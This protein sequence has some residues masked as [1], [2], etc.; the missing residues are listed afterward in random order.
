MTSSD[1]SGN[2]IALGR[3]G[4][5]LANHDGS[6]V[7]GPTRVVILGEDALARAA[8]ADRLASQAH[9]SVIAQAASAAG[10]AAVVEHEPDVVL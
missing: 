2:W 4:L 5:P 7:A 1:G 8:L 9:V 10:E 6:A 3:M